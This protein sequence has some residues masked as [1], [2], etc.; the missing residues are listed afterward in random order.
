MDRVKIANLCR[1]TADAR[2]SNRMQVAICTQAESS[3]SSNRRCNSMQAIACS[4]WLR[5]NRGIRD[6][7]ISSSSSPIAPPISPEAAAVVRPLRPSITVSLNLSLANSP[8]APQAEL[9]EI[10][11]A[12]K[13]STSS[14][15][16]YLP[17]LHL[18]V[19]RVASQQRLCKAAMELAVS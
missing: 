3:N 6:E 18:P 15:N 9:V 11:V 17:R 13:A 8:T 14:N 19:S 4:R 12:S 7:A 16:S 10:S 1:R 5:S 2:T